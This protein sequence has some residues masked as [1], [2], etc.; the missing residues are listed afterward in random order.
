MDSAFGE[1]QLLV[2]A[3]AMRDSIIRTRSMVRES[4]SGLQATSILDFI[5]TISGMDEVRWCGP[6]VHDT[7][8][9]G[10]K[11]SSTATVRCITMTEPQRS[12]GLRITSTV[13]QN[14]RP[15]GQIL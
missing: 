11:E 14:Q 15:E 7:K 5:S 13:A 9:I 3:T 4:S 6:M 2:C 8:D 10:S 12:V 1:L